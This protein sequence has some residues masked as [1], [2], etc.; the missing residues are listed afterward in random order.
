MN[1]CVSFTYS[2]G[3]DRGILCTIGF[4]DASN[5]TLM[6][7][8]PYA[9]TELLCKAKVLLLHYIFTIS[10]ISGI[11]PLYIQI[12]CKQRNKVNSKLNSSKSFLNEL[13]QNYRTYQ[14]YECGSLYQTVVYNNR[15]LGLK[16]TF[17][18]LYLTINVELVDI[19]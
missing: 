16:V 2:D 17:K 18:W 10:Q 5:C 3:M 15:L 19:W 1:L 4:S 11:V 6:H 7:F 13:C 12:R 9:K 8:V 14:D